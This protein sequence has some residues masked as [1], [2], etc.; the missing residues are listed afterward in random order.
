MTTREQM[1][2]NWEKVRE[3]W[4]LAGWEL[5]FSHHRRHLGYCRPRRKVISL[6]LPFMEINPFPVMMDTL[7][8]ETAHTLHYIETGRT[9]HNG[10]WKEIAR[11]VGCTPRR[12]AA[13]G[14]VALPR[15]KYVGKCPECGKETHFYRQV[16]RSYS[17][18][19]CTNSYDPRY[20]LRIREA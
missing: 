6:S 14:D 3:K 5:K 18:S 10:R 16:R 12:C 4:G 11:M 20:K 1:L 8:H 2:R 7:L 19:V 9:N 13:G 17:C 15:G